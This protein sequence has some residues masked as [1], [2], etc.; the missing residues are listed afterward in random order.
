MPLP[1]P[2][3]PYT[4]TP[5]TG[6]LHR[7]VSLALNLHNTLLV[8]SLLKL[9]T[10]NGN[11]VGNS[12][13]SQESVPLYGSPTTITFPL[14]PCSTIGK[15]SWI[16]HAH[17]AILPLKPLCT[18]S[19]TALLP[20]SFGPKSSLI[21]H[22]FSTLQTPQHHGSKPCLPKASSQASS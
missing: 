9:L 17:Y 11:G 3:L 6:F 18:Y 22:L 21:S 4:M 16:P 2:T 8:V 7:M 1:S 19:V 15:S 14:N 20:P 13:L 5:P 10:T 12:L